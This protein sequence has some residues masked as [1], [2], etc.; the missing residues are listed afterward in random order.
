MRTRT[1]TLQPPLSHGRAR[2]QA[3]A[4][5]RFP[6]RLRGGELEAGTAIVAVG[7]PRLPWAYHHQY[8]IQG[9]PI[10]MSLDDLTGPGDAAVRN[11]AR[12]WAMS[13]NEQV[14]YFSAPRRNLLCDL[15][16]PSERASGFS[17]SETGT[18]RRHLVSKITQIRAVVGKMP[19]CTA[20]RGI[21]C[22]ICV[23]DS[24]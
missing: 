1:R 20:N 5:T 24:T 19:R 17:Q 8:V 4:S 6:L 22:I 7:A 21:V 11:A 15:D 13:P 14:A 3:Q 10:Q 9:D 12:K 2:E 18:S 23:C 16:D